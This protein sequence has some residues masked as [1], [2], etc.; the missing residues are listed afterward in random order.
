[1]DALFAKMNEVK[2]MGSKA[3]LEAHQRQL[4]EELEAA[5]RK[6]LEERRASDLEKKKQLEAVCHKFVAQVCCLLA[7]MKGHVSYYGYVACMHSATLL[8][9]SLTPMNKRSQAHTEERPRQSNQ[10][11]A[12]NQPLMQQIK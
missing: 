6:R 11:L 1:M 7:D 8:E 9:Y 5:S 12:W 2:K 3:F 10:A 4:D